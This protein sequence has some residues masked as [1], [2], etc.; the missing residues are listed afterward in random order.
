MS[1]IHA[2]INWKFGILSGVR[3]EDD[4]LVE[5]PD[6]IP[7]EE[8]QSAWI[9]EYEEHI[10]SIEYRKKRAAEYLRIEDQL[11]MQYWDLVNGTTKWK[12]HIASVKAQFPNPKIL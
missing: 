1:N 3:V 11:D 4:V 10:A 2:A 6:G 5:Y 7:S 9:T 8:D 12:D